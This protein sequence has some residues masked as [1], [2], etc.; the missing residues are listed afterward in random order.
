MVLQLRP[1]GAAVACYWAAA[2]CVTCPTRTPRTPPTQQAALKDIV[3]TMVGKYGPHVST[4]FAL[5]TL[6]LPHGVAAGEFPAYIHE[7]RS[8]HAPGKA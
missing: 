6:P 7:R 5:S 1:L 2:S 3:A 4:S 8:R